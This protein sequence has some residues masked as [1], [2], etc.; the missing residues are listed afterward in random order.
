M[1]FVHQP[2]S[3]NNPLLLDGPTSIPS[4]SPPPPPR[5]TLPTSAPRKPSNRDRRPKLR[6]S[7]DACAASKVRCNKEHPICGRCSM[8]GSPCI[9]GVSRKHGKPGRQR[10]WNRDGTPFVKATKQP[11]SNGKFSKFRIRPNPTPHS[12][13][14][15]LEIPPETTS[16]LSSTWS[17]TP[18]LPKTPAYE[19]GMTPEPFTEPG[20]MTYM[21]SISFPN[22]HFE[23][24]MMPTFPP[25][26]NLRESLVKKGPIHLDVP[27][28]QPFDNFGGGN[29][30][31]PMTYP[32]QETPFDPYLMMSAC[33]DSSPQSIKIPSTSSFNPVRASTSMPTTH[34]CYTSAYSTL[35]SLRILDSNTA[36]AHPSA[37]TQSFESTLSVIRLAVQSIS[38]GLSCSCASDPH[39]VLLYG[40]IL[41]RLLTWC[42]NTAA[43]NIVTPTTKTG[44]ANSE[45]NSPASS[46]RSSVLSSAVSEPERA[47]SIG[48]QPLQFNLYQYTEVERA[49]HRRQAVLAEIK[50]CKQLVDAFASWR[51][52]EQA[53][54]LYEFLGTW[55]NGRFLETIRQVETA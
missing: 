6:A 25:E 3:W 22:A 23:S 2:E 8:N 21:E 37:E 50:S 55:L 11:S 33:S 32:Y 41:T 30:G 1:S 51:G 39:L 20:D 13:Q 46:G 34:S 27:D 38:Q 18:S 5:T 4:S 44:Y 14:P 31:T 12:P 26:K 48:S 24:E 29:S 40:S 45:I 52:T 49:N 54:I 17:P 16:A 47:F 35:E 7:C 36:Q 19:F 42:Q 10:K 9:Y 53:D 43:G 28:V 15:L